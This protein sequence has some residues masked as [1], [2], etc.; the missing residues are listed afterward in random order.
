MGFISEPFAIKPGIIYSQ[1]VYTLNFFRKGVY[2][3]SFC[4]NK[5]LVLCDP[6]TPFNEITALF[7]AF[8]VFYFIVNSTHIKNVYSKYIHHDYFQTALTH[9]KMCI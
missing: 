9:N 7:R 2:S 6:P 1:S 8:D 5:K 3:Y 4:N